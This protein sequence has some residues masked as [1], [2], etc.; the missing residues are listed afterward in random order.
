MWQTSGERERIDRH[1]DD[2]PAQQK[3]LR[4]SKERSL[5]CRRKGTVGR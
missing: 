5:V 3:R 2:V 1:I 4:P